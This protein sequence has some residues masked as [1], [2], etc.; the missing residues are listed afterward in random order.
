MRLFA[1]L[2]LL[3]SFA[4]PCLAGGTGGATP[5]NFL[6]LDADARPVALGGAY[7]AIASDA[8]SMLYNP[9]G[10]AFL[11]SHQANLMHAEHFQDVTQEYVA[12]AINEP[13]SRF[14]NSGVG[15]ML[16]T[17]GYGDINRTTLSNPRGDGLGSFGIRDWAI[18]AG[19]GTRTRLEW[20]G[21]GAAVKYLRED[22]DT[23]SAQ[24]VAL[25]L[26][27]KTEL[28]EPLGVP[29]AFGL[30]LQNLG[31]KLKYQSRNEDLPLNLKAGLAYRLLRSGTLALDVNQPREGSPTVHVGAEYVANKAVAIRLG[32]NGR[33][34][35]GAGITVG[36][37][38]ILQ[39]FGF[40]YAFVPFGDLGSAHRISLSYRWGAGSK[41]GLRVLE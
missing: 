12:V 9:A 25:D 21:V 11:D 5:L 28:Q 13:W 27:L 40:D 2:A 34:E 29:L 18:A 31:S 22:I 3:A 32:Y 4:A 37:G 16:N 17:V 20:L 19:F 38:L 39:H 26:G 15:F 41:T 36:G 10:L 33:N 1:S 6:F 24:A 23:F 7:A 8:N 14:K 30:A 35:A